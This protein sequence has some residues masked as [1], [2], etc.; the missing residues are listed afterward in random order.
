M[1]EVKNEELRVLELFA[2]YGSQSL[3]LKMAGIP[4]KVVGISEIEPNAIKAYGMLHGKNIPNFGD[5]TKINPKDIPDCDFVTYSFPCTDLSSLGKRKGMKEGSGTASSLIWSV[6]GIIEEKRPKYLM[7]EN[8]KGLLSKGNKSEFTRWCKALEGL[9]YTNSYQLLNA[10]DFCLPQN[11]ERV[12]MISVLD[13]D[14]PFEIPTYYNNKK[15]R[16]TIR[17][18]M[19]KVVD[20][21]YNLKEDYKDTYHIDLGIH[22]DKDKI[23]KIGTI[24]P[25]Y[26][27]RNAG[28]IFHAD[29]ISPTVIHGFGS[30]GNNVPHIYM[31]T[32]DGV[33]EIRR[34]TPTECFRLQGVRDMYIEKLINSGEFS[35]TKLYCLAGNSI[36]V[37]MMFPIFKTLFSDYKK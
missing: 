6:Y 32:N 26:G 35:D 37:N 15:K 34:L 33:D 31:G 2:G 19:D 4:H 17:D 27:R 1:V 11:R 8:V 23:I 36:P 5:I 12:I 21:K 18:I 22:K 25:T 14:K 3:A 20:P 16:R 7:L 28:L 9:G 10:S 29:G 24:S 30:G 13:A